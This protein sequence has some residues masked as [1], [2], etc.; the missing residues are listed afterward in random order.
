MRSGYIYVYDGK[1][2]WAGDEGIYWL[3][4]AGNGD[5]HAFYFNDDDGVEYAEGYLR[6]D[7]FSLR[8]LS[9]VLDR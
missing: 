3:A 6:Y 8:C 5:S 1:L 7:G 9:T 4:V 2:K